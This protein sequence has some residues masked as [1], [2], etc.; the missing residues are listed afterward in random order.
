MT[1]ERMYNPVNLMVWRILHALA[2]AFPSLFVSRLKG[3]L[4]SNRTGKK[5]DDEPRYALSIQ[6][7]SKVPADPSHVLEANLKSHKHVIID[8]AEEESI[9][10]TRP[11]WSGPESQS[12][13]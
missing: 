5:S 11:P 4:P 7:Y 1:N 12:Q 13:T 10:W 8:T 2:T 3:A 6:G 9:L